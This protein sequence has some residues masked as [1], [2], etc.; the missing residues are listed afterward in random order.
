MITHILFKLNSTKE[1]KKLKL[2]TKSNEIV[3]EEVIEL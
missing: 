3:I 2:L 1:T